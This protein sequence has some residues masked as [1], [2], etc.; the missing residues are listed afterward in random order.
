MG[1]RKKRSIVSLKRREKTRDQNK[2]N[3]NKPR[4]HRKERRKPNGDR[5]YN[6]RLEEGSAK[7]GNQERAIIYPIPPRHRYQANTLPS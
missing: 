6:E 1:Y 5:E 7:K 3:E 4:Y 2:K